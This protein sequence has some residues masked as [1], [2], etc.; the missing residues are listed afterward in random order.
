MPHQK[1]LQLSLLALLAQDKL[2]ICILCTTHHL[3]NHLFDRRLMKDHLIKPAHQWHV[4]ILLFSMFSAQT[5]AQLF[6]VISDEVQ[7]TGGVLVGTV[8]W[9]EVAFSAGNFTGNG[10]M[11]WTVESG[12]QDI[13]QYNIMGNVMNVMDDV[14]DGF[15]DITL[16]VT[17]YRQY[18]LLGRHFLRYGPI[19]ISS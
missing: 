16:D 15:M 3:S 9:T 6:A 14:A 13:L 1:E 5:T 18:P 4:Y 2:N 11:T 10:S 8:P 19:F 12:D 7:P 17:E